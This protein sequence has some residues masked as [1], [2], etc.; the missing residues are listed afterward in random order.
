MW[1]YVVQRRLFL[2]LITFKLKESNRKKIL[3]ANDNHQKRSRA[4][5]LILDKIN[6][7]SKLS[8]DKKGHCI[9]I[10]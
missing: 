7:K 3:N 8:Q 9:I 1:L 4:A 6:L 5:I 10:K 2:D